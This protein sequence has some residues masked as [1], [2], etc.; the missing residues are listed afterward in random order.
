MN[1][2]CMKPLFLGRLLFSD[3]MIVHIV[4]QGVF[5]HGV[6]DYPRHQALAAVLRG[7]PYTHL[8]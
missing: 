4:D 2:K 6:T 3:R 5:Q 7:K 8:T 1:N